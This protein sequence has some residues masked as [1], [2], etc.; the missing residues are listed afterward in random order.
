[1]GGNYPLTVPQVIDSVNAAL[2]TSSAQDDRN[3]AALLDAYNY[4]PCPLN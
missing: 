3:L 1:L 2:A 4:L